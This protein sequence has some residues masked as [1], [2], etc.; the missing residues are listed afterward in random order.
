M[1]GGGG[2]VVEDDGITSQLKSYR[3]LPFLKLSTPFFLTKTIKMRSVNE[4]LED[5]YAI[6]DYWRIRW[7][8]RAG[9]WTKRQFLAGGM[10]FRRC[11]SVVVVGCLCERCMLTLRRDE[12]RQMVNYWERQLSSLMEREHRHEVAVARHLAA[13]RIEAEWPR[14]REVVD[15]VETPIVEERVGTD[16]SEEESGGA[17]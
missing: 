9:G 8:L 12:A 7:R 3:S 15:A 1:G 6:A 11:C 2:G 5:D 13:R 14:R 17:Q 16:T 4:T 10:S